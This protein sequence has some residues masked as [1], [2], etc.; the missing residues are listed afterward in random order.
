M[1]VC[2]D[3]S[4]RICRVAAVRL[5]DG[6]ISGIWLY[7]FHGY[8]PSRGFVILT[9]YAGWQGIGSMV[10]FTPYAITHVG[11]AHC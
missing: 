4:F 1:Q 8:T 11:F 5:G 6:R 2:G 9:P 7:G 10:Y 3:A